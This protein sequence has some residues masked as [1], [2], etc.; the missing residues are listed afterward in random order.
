MTTDARPD[1]IGLPA[2]PLRPDLQARVDAE[3]SV[4]TIATPDVARYYRLLA[5]ELRSVQ[6]GDQEALL[7]W[8]ALTQVWA[9]RAERRAPPGRTL[10]EAADAEFSRQAGLPT[11][12]RIIRED[13]LG[14]ALRHSTYF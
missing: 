4:A 13:L 6:L 14:R 9:A 5:R 7:I 11:L 1:S 3:R 8:H 12:D 2:T 10:V